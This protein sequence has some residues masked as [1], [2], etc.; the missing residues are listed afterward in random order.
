MLT[1]KINTR[2][3]HATSLVAS[4]DAT[5]YYLQ[6]VFVEVTPRAVLYAATDGHSMVVCREELHA[7]E[8]SNTLC[9][10]WIIPTETC[11]A[12]KPGKEG[13][14]R[15]MSAPS[16]TNAQ[17]TL[18]DRIF[19]AI[20]GTFPAWRRV[21]PSA[22]LMEKLTPENVP[23]FNWDKLAIFNKVGRMLADMRPGQ[24]AAHLHHIAGGGPA[25]IS[26]R[27]GAGEAFGVLMPL[28]E[29]NDAWKRPH[30]VDAKA[31]E[32]IAAE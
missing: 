17:L 11:R 32:A 5:R 1:A 12:F 23:H 13:D 28:R 30:W 9:G 31:P 18:G 16:A 7:D 27:E 14:H 10:A 6:G 2:K 3:L 20:D 19:T 22:D 15:T 8:E 25:A 29:S 4:T 26:F 24:Q 21:L